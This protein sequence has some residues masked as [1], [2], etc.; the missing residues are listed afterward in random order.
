M[1]RELC[2]DQK[3]LEGLNVEDLKVFDCGVTFKVSFLVPLKVS[4][5]GSLELLFLLFFLVF[6]KNQK[7]QQ[8]KGTREGNLQG[9]QE[10]N[11]EGHTTIENLQTFNVF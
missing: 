10:G 8:L 5:P 7:K 11:L 4:F 1:N 2:D 9:N 3:Y 6:Q